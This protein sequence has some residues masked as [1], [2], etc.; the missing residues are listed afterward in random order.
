MNYTDEFLKFIK[1]AKS[2]YHA[3][4]YFKNR[5][6][7]NGFI[8]LNENDKFN[9]KCGNKY[10]FT[11][12][13]SSLFIFTIPNDLNNIGFNI[14]AAHLDSP[15]LKLKPNALFNKNGYYCLDTEIYGGP[16][17]SSFVDRPLDIAG[18][19]LIN[20]DGIIENKLFSF[21][22]GIVSIPNLCIH[23]NRDI[24][25][26]F[27]Y[28]PQ[29]NLIPILGK[30]ECEMDLLDLISKKSKI[31]KDDIL[32]YDLNVALNDRGEKLGLNDEFIMAPQID[33]LESSYALFEGILNDL[34]P[35][36]N[37]LAL[38][39]NEEIGSKTRQGAS[40]NALEITLDRILTSLNINDEDRYIIYANS[41]M[42]S[43]D[44]AHAFHPLYANKYDD[45]N[46]AYLNEGVVIKS[47]A[48]GNYSTDGYS[49]AIFK[50]L[51]ELADTK[52]QY[53]SNR[54]DIAGGSTLACLSLEHVSIPTVDIGL[55]E[56]AMHSS[57]EMCGSY[58]IMELIKVI[59]KFYQIKINHINDSKSKIGE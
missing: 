37:V 38:F 32:A 22:K 51:C 52:Y 30:A 14:S 59:K 49:L 55:P 7:D 15:T 8:E 17:Y 20:N 25:K 48:R 54:S 31:K 41:F 24:N 57:Y 10:F 50:K 42:I 21:D 53:M 4:D 2:Q 56:L 3:C 34:G 35:N 40:S 43:S 5:L 9:L 44:N 39:D 13:N 36:I 1:Y 19:I 11:R 26:E 29:E 16:I 33:N 46:K 23:F 18:R 12:N 58:D 28:N 27:Q 47:S 6:L 45:L